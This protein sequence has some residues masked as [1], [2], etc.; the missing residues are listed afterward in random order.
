MKSQIDRITARIKASGI[1]R[2]QTIVVRDQTR[3]RL[4][5]EIHDLHPL[6]KPGSLNYDT[7]DGIVIV[8]GVQIETASRLKAQRDHERENRR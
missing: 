6:S 8:R 3:R 2:G 1:R 4:A 5:E 7:W